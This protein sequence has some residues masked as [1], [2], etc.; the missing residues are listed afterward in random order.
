MAGW[1]FWKSFDRIL[2]V[3][4]AIEVEILLSKRDKEKINRTRIRAHAN[5]IYTYLRVQRMCCVSTSHEIIYHTIDQCQVIGKREQQE[6][7]WYVYIY[8]RQ[9]TCIT[10]IFHCI[11]KW[12]RRH[13]RKY[14]ITFRKC[15]EK[16]SNAIARVSANENVTDISKYLLNF[17]LH[18]DEILH[19]PKKTEFYFSFLVEN[20]HFSFW[21][22]YMC[23]F[24]WFAYSPM[25]QWINHVQ[26]HNI[27]YIFIDV[28]MCVCFVIR[29]N[30]INNM[31]FHMLVLIPS[32][33]SL[34]H[35]TPHF[36]NLVRLFFPMRMHC[37]LS[38]LI[39]FTAV[40]FP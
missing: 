38:D 22:I 26:Y 7:E 32:I 3:F 34:F 23:L 10:C 29:M 24:A 25:N 31:P 15:N 2:G 18:T 14:F 27:G 40:F 39:L 4:Y 33:F 12:K 6:E 30:I 1:G 37:I 8:G 13:K 20:R 19:Q 28:F 36:T 35:F 21:K 16:W 17:F 5:R 11:I 9:I